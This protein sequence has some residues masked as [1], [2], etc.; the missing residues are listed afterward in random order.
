[1]IDI[2]GDELSLAQKMVKSQSTALD[3]GQMVLAEV[4]D[5]SNKKLVVLLADQVFEA[6]G[7]CNVLF[8][9]AGVGLGGGPLTTD[10]ETIHKVMEINTYGPIHGCMAFVDRMKESAQPGIIIN[11]GSKQ[12]IT[13]PPGNVFYNMSKAALKVY[14]EGLEHELLLE[15]LEGTCKLR[16]ALLIPGWVNTSIL[17]KTERAKAASNGESF[18]PSKVFFHEDKPHDGAWNPNQVIDL[19]ISEL[20]AGRFYI[21]CP[22]NEVDRETDN[23]RILWSAQDITE[24]RPP[25]SRWHPGFKEHFTSYLN[26]AKGTK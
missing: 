18:D 1:M 7:K 20:D 9:N 6:T 21:L 24:N 14:T 11:T 17:L 26:A 22:D 4:L 15:R 19:M 5:V 8:N 23:L 2:E 10:F 16:A 3:K 12:G 25:L 13:A